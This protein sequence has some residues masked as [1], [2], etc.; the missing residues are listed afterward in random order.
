MAVTG[1]SE[2]GPKK[3]GDATLGDVPLSSTVV[4]FFW[5]LHGTARS[6]WCCTVVG[7]RDEDGQWDYA[8]GRGRGRWV[9]VT[10][11]RDEQRDTAQTAREMSSMVWAAWWRGNKEAGPGTG[12][13]P[14]SN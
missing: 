13:R 12:T 4:A 3:T 5:S 1:R 7:D 11:Q 10:A 6:D 9:K 8:Y 14:G 2:G